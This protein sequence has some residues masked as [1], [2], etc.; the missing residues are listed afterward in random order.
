[1]AAAT[2]NGG[3]AAIF[4]HAR[5]AASR[6]GGDANWDALARLKAAC[7]LPVIGNG[8]V[9]RAADAE[10]MLR[11]TGVDG[12]MI[13]RA[14][15]GNP[16]IFRQIRALLASRPTADPTPAERRAVIA[17]HLA[18]LVRLKTLECRH[19]RRS[20][21]DPSR[22]AAMLFR[23]TLLHYLAGFDGCG[24]L[25]R[26]LNSLT[27]VEAVMAAVDRVLGLP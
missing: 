10:R 26:S 9:T 3:G 24:E 19:R 5:P 21:C 22:S 1:V 12:V 11:Q 17:E 23:A 2:E 20:V 7:R 25:R 27:S 18:R 8:G 4:V 15:I 6:H 14:A 16:W 13:G